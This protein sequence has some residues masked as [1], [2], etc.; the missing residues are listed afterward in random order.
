MSEQR[1]V[2][3]VGEKKFW[4]KFNIFNIFP[5]VDT[6]TTSY[7]PRLS[8]TECSQVP[9]DVS[10]NLIQAGAYP[11]LK[12]DCGHDTRLRCIHACIQNVLLFTVI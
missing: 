10:N 2:V 12:K 7:I 6:R 5:V 8:N 9:S 3:K 1:T 4:K 11:T